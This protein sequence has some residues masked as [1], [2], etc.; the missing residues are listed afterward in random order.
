MI[1]LF[2]RGY[3]APK[4]LELLGQCGKDVR[5]RRPFYVELG[6]NLHLGDNVFI[7]ADCMLLDIGMIMI[8]SNTMLGPRVQIHTGFH[9]KVRA[10]DCETLIKD[11]IIGERVW[12]GAGAIILPGVTIGRDATIGAGS[13]VTKDVPVHATVKGNPARS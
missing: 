5:I 10:P 13:V 1:Q 4:K 3:V 12:I 8:G 11:V 6:E 9:E 2:D 7:N